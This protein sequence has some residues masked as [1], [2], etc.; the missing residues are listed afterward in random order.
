MRVRNVLHD[1][2]RVCMSLEAA[3]VFIRVNDVLHAPTCVIVCVA[4]S[5]RLICVLVTQP[6]V[7]VCVYVCVHVC[8]HVSVWYNDSLV[9]NHVR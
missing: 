4:R 6:C 7:H 9:V 8:V 2:N 3:E 5:N 1:P